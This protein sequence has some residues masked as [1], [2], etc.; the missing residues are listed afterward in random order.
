[1]PVKSQRQVELAGMRIDRVA[2]IGVLVAR[3]GEQLHGQ[4][5]GVAVH[6]PPRQ[7]RANLGHVLG[8]VAHSRYEDAQ[9][10]AIAGKPQHHRQREPWIGAR[11]QNERPGAVDQ[12]VPDG[13]EQRDDAL[14][15]RRAGLHHTRCDAAGEIVLKE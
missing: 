1:V 8:T 2:H 14:A 7:H 4:N 5:V 9:H 11:E 12:D 10:R 13:S 6:D 15:D 3:T